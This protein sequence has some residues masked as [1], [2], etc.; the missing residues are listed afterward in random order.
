MRMDWPAISG[1]CKAS[2]AQLP[3]LL[4]ITIGFGE[5]AN[6]MEQNG[7]FEILIKCGCRAAHRT[8][9]LWSLPADTSVSNI[10]R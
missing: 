5:E 6:M 1:S 2:A 8:G 10:E 3:S 7:L 4:P 9:G